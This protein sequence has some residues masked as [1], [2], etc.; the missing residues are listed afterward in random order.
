MRYSYLVTEVFIFD[1]EIQNLIKNINIIENKKIE[2][3]TFEIH[4]WE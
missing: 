1:C 4:S 3:K 2:E